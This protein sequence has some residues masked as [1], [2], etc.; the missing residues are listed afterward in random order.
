MYVIK[1][2]QNEVYAGTYKNMDGSYLY[3]SNFINKKKPRVF[4]TLKGV[5]N[6]LNKLWNKIPY[7]DDSDL[8]IEI[9]SEEDYH[10]HLVS[11]GVDF[12]KEKKL[13]EEKEK[14]RYWKKIFNPIK[15]E[16]E[17]KK[18]IVIDNVGILL[19]LMPY[20]EYEYEFTFD[21]DLEKDIVIKKF[22]TEVQNK[23]E[24]M[25]KTIKENTDDL[26]SLF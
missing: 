18:V 21:P 13:H 16:V 17:V 23:G 20:S 14:Q 24:S 9:W 8:R 25:I 26:V 22:C 19:Y 5:E 10:N 6:H 12:S 4:K 11:I 3:S 15:G 1:F 2:N 7:P